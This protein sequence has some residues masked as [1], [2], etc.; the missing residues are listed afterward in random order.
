MF[1]NVFIGLQNFEILK[2]HEISGKDQ[3]HNI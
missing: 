2:T 3:K 1:S